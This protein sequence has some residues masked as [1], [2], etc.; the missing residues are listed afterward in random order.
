MVNTNS[1]LLASHNY[2]ILPNH[3]RKGHN[4]KLSLQYTLF[5]VKPYPSIYD[6]FFC[7]SEIF[8]SECGNDDF[9]AN[10]NEYFNVFVQS[11]RA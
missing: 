7:H 1:I 5:V 3:N 2:N 4:R 6:G 8:S 11:K 10:E 9:K